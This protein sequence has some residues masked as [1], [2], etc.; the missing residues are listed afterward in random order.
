MRLL[1]SENFQKIWDERTRKG[2]DLTVFFPEL[3]SLDNQI[4]ACKKEAIKSELVDLATQETKDNNEDEIEKLRDRRKEYLRS[5]LEK[6]AQTLDNQFRNDDFVVGLRRGPVRGEPGKEKITYTIGQKK[7]GNADDFFVSRAVQEDLKR[8]FKIRMPNRKQQA[9]QVFQLLYDEVAYWVLKTDVIS[10]F[11]E[12]KP[13][14]IIALL[15]QNPKVSSISIKYIRSLLNEYHEHIGEKKGLPRGVGISTLLSEVVMNSIDQKVKVLPNLISYFRY[16]DDLVL[17][18]PP[19]EE[20]EK[21]EIERKL[22]DYFKDF[23]LKLHTGDKRRSVE[24]YQGASKAQI[25][26][27]G[28]AYRVQKNGDT[29]KMK[30]ELTTERKEKYS[31][32]IQRAFNVYEGYKNSSKRSNMAGDQKAS[33]DAFQEWLLVE[34]LKF[35]ATNTRLSGSKSNALTGIYFSNSLLS[36][37][38]DLRFLRGIINRCLKESTLDKEIQEVIRSIDFEKGF[39]DKTFKKYSTRKLK[40]LTKVW[41]D[42]Q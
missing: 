40:M 26:F 22:D 15:N 32:R 21:E 19:V 38:S 13:E 2:E 33:S 24:F 16:V 10:F 23:G 20:S 25:D 31:R 12:I 17:F 29:H 5:E 41:I 6:L 42:V 4:S 28:Y 39:R 8:A 36:L 11:E 37:P 1:E 30:V 35:L 18:F 14:A 34:R 7:P 27:L 9:S 3:R